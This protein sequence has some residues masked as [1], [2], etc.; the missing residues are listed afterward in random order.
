MIEDLIEQFGTAVSVKRASNSTA[1]KYGYQNK[2][3]TI[4]Y[5]SVKIWI[6]E[7]ASSSG[8]NQYRDSGIRESPVTMA[9]VKSTTLL[10]DQDLIYVSGQIFGRVVGVYKASSPTGGTNHY[11]IGI[12]KP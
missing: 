6:Q 1:D 7:P 2:T 4:V 5:A 11:E 10:Q 12:E 9:Y 3:G 8:N